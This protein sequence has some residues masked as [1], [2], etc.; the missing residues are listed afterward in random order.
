[1]DQTDG[2][3]TDKTSTGIHRRNFLG[4]GVAALT[5]PFAVSLM[6]RGAMAAAGPVMLGAFIRV[7]PDNRVTVILGSTEMG[8]GILTGLSQLVAEELNLNWSQISAE[9]APASILFPNP[10]GNPLFGAQLT[11]GSTSMMGWYLPMRTA[12]AI[13]RDVLLAAA[14]QQ[15]GGAWTLVQGGKLA[16]G[17]RTVKFADVLDVAA[18]LTPPATATLATTSRFIGKRIARLDV[19]AKT[20]GSAIFGMDVRVPGMVYAAIVHCPTIGGVVAR[21]PA[22]TTGA[23]LVNLTTAVGVVA[24]NTWSAMQAARQIAPGIKWT[25]PADLAALDSTALAATAQILVTSPTETPFIAESIGDPQPQTAAV[26]IDATYALPFLAHAAMEVMNCTASVTASTCEIWVPTQGQQFIV[27][28][29]QALTG[30]PPEA[31]TVHSTFMGGGFG[32]KFEMDYLSQ[33]VLLSKTL[34][35]PVKLTWSREQDFH[36]DMFRPSAL[37]RVQA[38]TDDRGKFTALVYRNVSP[39]I[40]IQRGQISS[41]N[42][43]DTG[44]LA[45][46]IALPYKIAARRIEYVP[47]LPCDIPL[48]YWRSVGESYNTFAVESA[49]DELALAS[50]QDPMAFRR[51]LVGGSG[52]DTRALGVLNALQNLSG[53]SQTPRPG[54][55]RGMAFLKGFGSYIGL[56]AEVSKDIRGQMR[57]NRFYCAVDCGIAVNP[58]LIET[59]MQGGIA[60]GIS[61]AMWN[62]QTFDNGKPAVS[63]YNQYPVLKLGQMPDVQVRIVASTA[64]PGGIGETGVPCVAPALA[65]AWANLTGT[66]VRSLPFYPGQRMGDA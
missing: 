56:V 52:G 11:G 25:L 13:T 26:R 15:F 24:G 14:A 6:P 54:T 23:T 4:A 51:M 42:P 45:G 1:M 20:D 17:A 34:G 43:E 27:P 64:A 22:N 19:P 50:A 8:Q 30:L 28:T 7:S 40:N 29:V 59:Q 55:G 44:A 63:N 2:T 62:A 12:A 61:S 36:N 5:L 33:A 58:D 49:V 16:Q 35:K 66:R 21:M 47:L 46:A 48:G 41:S 57:V 60:H 37:I 9:H 32:R 18:T 31:V 39:S 53:W 10:Y 65:N 38:S 3:V